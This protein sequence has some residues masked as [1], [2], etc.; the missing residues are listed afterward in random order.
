[1]TFI[2]LSFI[3]AVLSSV[4]TSSY[5]GFERRT[6]DTQ[7]SA[8]STQ[9]WLAPVAVLVLAAAAAEAGVV[10]ADLGLA[11]GYR[12]WSGGALLAGFLV[13]TS[14]R[15]ALAAVAGGGCAGGLI[16]SLRRLGL[17]GRGLGTR[18]GGLGLGSQQEDVEH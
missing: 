6:K 7:H 8:L 14:V 2:W 3:S 9:H 15:L 11:G 18:A 1:M 12:G 17:R 5:D 16:R 13:A 10:T 4:S